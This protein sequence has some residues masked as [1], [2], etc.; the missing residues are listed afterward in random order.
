MGLK[1]GLTLTVLLLLG[2]DD[3]SFTTQMDAEAQTMSIKIGIAKWMENSDYN[4]NISGFKDSLKEYGFMEGVNVEYVERNP[5]GDE[6]IQREIIQEFIAMDVDLIYSL[7]T[8]GTLIAKDLTEDIPI[9]FSIVTFPVESG[10]VDSFESSGNNLV[11]T[12][13][14]VSVEKQL[15]LIYD[16]SKAQKIGFLHRQGESNSKIQFELMM[17]YAELK[18][19][20]VVE[21]KPSNLDE[22]ENSINQVISEIDVLYNAC[23]TLV[24]SGAEEIA[25]S[26]GLEN[27][28]P[29]FSCNKAGINSGALAGNVVDYK[30]IGEL[31]GLKAVVI[32]NGGNPSNILSEKQK[33]DNIFVNIESQKILEIEIPK[34]IKNISNLRFAS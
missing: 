18:G 12:S 19:I 24:Q 33:D 32:L 4:E 7:T 22:V 16:I 17:E 23:D 20:S 3:N 34:H 14:F 11:G 21:I 6:T 31:A 9:V 27:N 13:N 10:I 25:I 28:K 29:T 2:L 5:K 15:D 26:V 1:F 30:K 8:T